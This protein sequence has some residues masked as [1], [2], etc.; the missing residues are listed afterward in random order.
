MKRA[1]LILF[2][3]L[4]SA[5]SFAEV[6]EQ[7]PLVPPG[8]MEAWFEQSAIR[9]YARPSPDN[10]VEC[11]EVST[12][13]GAQVCFFISREEMNAALL[14]ASI[15]TEGLGK[16]AKGSLP[17]HQDRELEYVG[18]QAGGHDLQGSDLKEFYAKAQAECAASHQDANVCLNAEETEIFQKLILPRLERKEP[19]VV[20]GF[21]TATTGIPYQ[22]SVSHEVLHAQYFLDSTFRAT[23]DAFW[24]EKVTEHDKAE[25]RHELAPIYDEHNE[26]LMRNEFQAYIL[27]PDAES[28][29]LGRFV[30]KYQQPLINALKAKGIDPIWIQ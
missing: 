25:V 30:K 4:I 21:E 13:K 2:F 14:R 12:L 3:S 7:A 28:N 26:F 5:S 24:K 6:V 18:R 29:Q 19:L 10:Y 27:M 11:R 9:R 8:D 1:A 17:K 20:I 15:F 23:A 16:Y 22:Q